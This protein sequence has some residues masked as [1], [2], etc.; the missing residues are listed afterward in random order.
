MHLPRLKTVD[1][2]VKVYPCIMVTIS[3]FSEVNN[4]NNIHIYSV[5]NLITVL[6]RNIHV[7]YIYQKVIWKI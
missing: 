5:L 1:Q 6:E 2:K 3:P 4:N 7:A